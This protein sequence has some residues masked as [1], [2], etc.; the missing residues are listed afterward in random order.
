MNKLLVILSAFLTILFVVAVALNLSPYLR[1]PAP[2]FPD[3]QWE[4]SFVNTYSNIWLPIL[5]AGIIITLFYKF[6]TTKN[7]WFIKHEGVSIFIVFVLN[8]SFQFSLLF[9]NR[10][11]IN[12]LLSRIIN[13]DVNGYYSTALT[14]HSIPEFLSNYNSSV[15]S[16]FMHAQ[17]HPPLAVLFFYWINEFFKATPFLNSFIENISPST[18]L[19]NV[20]WMGLS[21]NEKLGALFSTFFIPLLVSLSAILLYLVARKMYGKV[22]ALRTLIGFTFVPSVLLFIPIND[23]FISIFPLSSLLILFKALEA[24][25][26]LLLALSGIVFAVGVYFS[27]SLLPILAIFAI[28]SIHKLGKKVSE[29][30]KLGLFFFFGF[31]I[32]PIFFWLLFKFNSIQMFQVLMQGL[33]ENR[34]YSTWIA[35]N[36]YDFLIFSGIPFALSYFFLFFNQTK[37][38]VKKRWKKMDFLFVSFT[39]MLLLIN[40]SGSVRGEVARIWIP[41]VPFYLLPIISFLTQ[42]KFTTI[43]FVIIFILQLLIV[44]AI[45]EYWVT[46]W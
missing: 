8:L 29:I 38:L 44:L 16:F 34:S 3:W 6:E 43:Q 13:P 18:N 24:R 21:A 32:I 1:G 28:L 7:K 27:I 35:Y 45:N 9:F 11:G 40:F 41:F 20:I 30:S 2:Y 39:I 26:R 23:T 15:L 19:I 25:S 37:L 22:V 12:G 42:K 46:F 33:P 5:T 10:A 36:L 17:G 14:I 31:L 4:Y